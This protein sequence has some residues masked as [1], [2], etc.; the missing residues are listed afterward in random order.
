[1]AALVGPCMVGRATRG[2]GSGGSGRPVRRPRGRAG[3]AA[4][5]VVVWEARHQG[6]RVPLVTSSRAFAMACA[7]MTVQLMPRRGFDILEW[8]TS[9]IGNGPGRGRSMTKAHPLLR[10]TSS[11]GQASG[12][13]R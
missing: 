5:A 2:Q 7:P 13:R 3:V 1:M 9:I 11:P 4:G 12:R 10:A 8:P 6:A